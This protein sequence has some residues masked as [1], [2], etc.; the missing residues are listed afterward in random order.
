VKISLALSP[1]TCACLKAKSKKKQKAKRVK[2]LN[3]LKTQI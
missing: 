1:K 2:T 3:G